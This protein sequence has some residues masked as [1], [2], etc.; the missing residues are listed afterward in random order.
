MIDFSML[1]NE[2]FKEDS[3]RSFIIDKI[4]ESFGFKVKDFSGDSKTDSIESSKTSAKTDSIESKHKLE[5]QLSRTQKTKVVVGSNK[6]INANLTPDYTLYVDDKTHCVLDAKAPSVNIAKDSKAEKQTLSYAIAF[7]TPYYALCNGYKFMLFKTDL[8]ES[9]L[10]I[11]LESSLKDSNNLA[12]LKQYLTT[13]LESLRQVLGSNAKKP[14]KSEEWYLNRPLPHIF[15]KPKK[16]QAQRYFG[17]TA[18]FTRQSW[19]VV[20]RHISTFTD[21]GDVVLDPFGGSGV[22]AIEA[23]MTGRI[24]IHTDLNPLS[25]FM[26]KAL[27]AKVNLA[28][29]QELSEK[30]LN[31]FENLKPK[32][33]K[34]IKEMLKNA[35]YYPNAIDKEF[36]DTATIKEQDSILWI[37]Q[38][39]IL[40]KGSDVDSILKLFTKRQLVELAILRKLIFKHTMP[41]GNMESREIKRAM[42]Y[43]LLL[44]FRNTITMCN[45]T[46]HETDARKG[47][48]GNSGV[49]SYYR[50]RIA[51]K[52]TIL[53]IVDIFKGKMQRVYKGKSELESNP[54][55]YNSYFHEIRGVVKEFNKDSAL[56]QGREAIYN[57]HIVNNGKK[58]FQADATNL[59]EI[60]S[61]SIDFI[62]TDPPYGAKIPYLDLSTMWN[63]WLDFPVDRIL[64]EKECIEKGSLEKSKYEYYDLMKKSLKEMYRVLKHDRWLAFCFQHQDPRLYQ[65]INE[66]AE[67]VGFE[68]MGAVRQDNGQATFK[69]RQNPATVLK[70]QIIIYFRKVDNPKSRAKVDVGMDIMEKMFKDIEEIIV[71]R[72]GASL[73]EIWNDLII[74]SMNHGY[75]HLIAGRFQ[76]FIPAINDRFELDSN[77]K[78]QL[79]KNASFTNYDIPLEKRVEY[80]IKSAL[81]D[82]KKENTG[83]R[84]DDLVLSIIPLSKNGIQANNALITEILN[85]LAKKDSTTG[86]WHLKP[87]EQTLFDM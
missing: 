64:R 17:C 71:E 43:S 23:M 19:D 44:A 5:M 39:E 78:Y 49:L 1:K 36:G 60:D 41:S 52:R 76:N 57:Y 31:E 8:Q 11:D 27:C 25:V 2:D 45:L 75:L 9:L 30:I 62:Y 20:A 46:Y 65:I 84:F 59:V 18:Y 13:P 26:V 50:Y 32:N 16:Q 77:S 70:G 58:I 47:K 42:R 72:S 6:E 55:F 81:D 51:S 7:K 54:N 74:K 85:K 63:A 38:D 68:Y 83:V 87:K 14:R 73:E 10:E 40:P 21:E 67:N 34:E 80:L 22:T 69:K 12:L 53:D 4:L 66:S 33:E 37:P 35:K 28:R 61:N 3:V 79:A 48:G 15:E 56:M 29:L 86:L 82:A 24:G